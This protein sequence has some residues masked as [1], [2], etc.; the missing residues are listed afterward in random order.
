M[1]YN[2]IPV[3]LNPRKSWGLEAVT[4]MNTNLQGFQKLPQH[5]QTYV[6]DHD[7]LILIFPVTWIRVSSQQGIYI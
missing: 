6:M 4:Y 2:P 3:D 1:T 7:L 5:L